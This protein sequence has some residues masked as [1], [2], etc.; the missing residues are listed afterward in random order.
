MQEFR[1]N[2]IEKIKTAFNNTEITYKSYDY[3]YECCLTLPVNKFYN[4]LIENYLEMYKKEL[5][6]KKNNPLHIQKKQRKIYGG[7]W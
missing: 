1:K 5:K 3:L 4:E 7:I 2:L 6:N